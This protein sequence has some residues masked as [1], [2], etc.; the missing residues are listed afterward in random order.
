MAKPKPS[1]TQGEKRAAETAVETLRETEAG[2]GADRA[3]QPGILPEGAQMETGALTKKKKVLKTLIKRRVLDA[4]ELRGL[5][6]NGEDADNIAELSCQMC[7]VDVMEIYSP[8]RFD[9]IPTETR[10][11]RRP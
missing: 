10:F 6:I 3:P 9:E 2:N 11:R 1:P 8:K 7:A 4:Y 5:T